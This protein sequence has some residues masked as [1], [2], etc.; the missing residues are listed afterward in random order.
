MTSLTRFHTKT[1][2]LQNLA[3]LKCEMDCHEVV[4]TS[5]NDEFRAIPHENIDSAESRNNIAMTSLGQF[6]ALSSSLRG[7]EAT[8]AIHKKQ[9]YKMILV[10]L[11]N[12]QKILAILNQGRILEYPSDSAK[13]SYKI[14]LRVDCHDSAFAESRNDEI[15]ANRHIKNTSSQ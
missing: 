6:H 8:E 10:F 15:G 5:C 2:N 7:S 14:N 9:N 11:W 12:P 3:T 13:S 1:Q 4:L